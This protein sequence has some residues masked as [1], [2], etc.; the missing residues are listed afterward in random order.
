MGQITYS[1]QIQPSLS[2]TYNKNNLQNVVNE[3]RWT[4]IA[5]YTPDGE[6]IPTF[7]TGIPGSTSLPTPNSNDFIAFENLTAQIVENWISSVVG[8]NKISEMEQ[9]LSAS[10]VENVTPTIGIIKAPWV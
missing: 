5:K 9:Q 1:W 8:T 10:I 3:V 2:V 7:T 6:T 4:F